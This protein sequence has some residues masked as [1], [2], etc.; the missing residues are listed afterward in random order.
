MSNDYYQGMK[1]KSTLLAPTMKALASVL[2][3][4]RVRHND[5]SSWKILQRGFVEASRDTLANREKPT[6]NTELSVCAG[7]PRKLVSQLEKPADNPRPKYA[8]AVIDQWI[9]NPKYQDKQGQ[10]LPLEVKGPNISLRTLCREVCGEVGY[11]LAIDDLEH[12]GAVVI[13]DG[14]AELKAAAIVSTGPSETTLYL[15]REAVKHLLQAITNNLT[16]PHKAYIQRLVWSE[17]IPAEKAQDVAHQLRAIQERANEECAKV[18]REAEE[19]GREGPCC[20][21]AAGVYVNVERIDQ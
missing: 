6:S 5:L 19:P 17:S 20:T 8:S 16:N 2:L 9:N 13:N 3:Q 10:P 12:S 7:V 14:I 11:K 15:V 1:K 21:V 4:F 18:L